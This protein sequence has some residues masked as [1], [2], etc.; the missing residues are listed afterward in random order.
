MLG[1][2]TDT[3]ALTLTWALSLILNNPS[4]LEK[5]RGEI[6]LHVGKERQVEESDIN[7][8][9][10]LQALVKETLRL[11]PPGPLLLPHECIEDCTVDGYHVTKGTRLLVNVSMIHRDPEFW[12][13]PDAFRPERFLEEHKEV[14]VRGNHFNLIPFG[15]GRRICPGISLGLQSVQL[16]L[17]NLVHGFDVK[18]ISEKP[19]DMTEAP[20]LSNVK[21]TPLNVFLSPRLP[22]H[23]YG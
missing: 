2:A 23:L 16:A 10:Y 9:T 7:N 1:A 5:I 12:S 3:T 13:D 15:G 17:A 19:I 11:Y 21:A 4:T 8:L 6:D 14:D 20:G 18:K 22:S